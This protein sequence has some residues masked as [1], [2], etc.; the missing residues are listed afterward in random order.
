MRPRPPARR[1]TV[2]Q[3]AASTSSTTDDAAVTDNG[4]PALFPEWCRRPAA[5][6]ASVNAIPRACAYA[7]SAYARSCRGVRSSAAAT[8]THTN[9]S[10]ELIGRTDRSADSPLP[11]GSVRRS[12][13]SSTTPSGPGRRSCVIPRSTDAADSPRYDAIVADLA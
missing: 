6:S 12:E 13:N 10:A 3:P 4:T 2:T 5:N 1:R 11:P 9:A 7:I 8:G